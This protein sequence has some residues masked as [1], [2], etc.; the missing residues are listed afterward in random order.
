MD[1]IERCSSKFSLA[2]WPNAKLPS[3]RS[4]TIAALARATEQDIRKFC[5]GQIAHYKIP[6]YVRFVEQF[7][8]TITGKVQKFVMRQRMVDELQLQET[9]TA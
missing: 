7:P 8:M 2:S 9:K 1:R 4:V 5:Q 3:R 6:R